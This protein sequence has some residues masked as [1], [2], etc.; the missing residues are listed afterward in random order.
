MLDLG[1]LQRRL[2][3]ERR[4]RQAAEELIEHKSL[5]LY[6]ARI[7]AEVANR[8]KSEFLAN[9]GHELRTPLNAIIGFAEIVYGDN[10]DPVTERQREYLAEV[11]AAGRRL[12]DLVAQILEMSSLS[13]GKG[14]LR[15]TKIDP[16]SLI[17]SC[18]EHSKAHA[19]AAEVSLRDDVDNHL[20]PMEA[21][22]VAFKKI[23][24]NLLDN[25]IRFTAKGGCVTVRAVT[26]ERE[27]LV[28]Q[29]QDTGIGIS[30]E[31]LSFVTQPFYQVDGGR[32]RQKEGAGLGLAIANSLVEGHGGTLALESEPGVGTMAII[33]LPL[34]QERRSA[35]A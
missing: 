32:N 18:V 12:C 21:D 5:E 1:I 2:D 29:I 30:R 33:R 17:R 10:R 3:R 14:D 15:I 34:K 24:L 16:R 22:P 25:A 20:P 9:V 19:E 7:D 8:A 13:L 27:E 28:I 35:V 6:R 23:L 4:A 26:P 31:H 11:I